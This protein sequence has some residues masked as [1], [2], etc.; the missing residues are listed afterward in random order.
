MNDPSIVAIIPARY[1]STRLPA[2]PLVDLRGKPMIRR[3]VEQVKKSELVGRVIVATDDERIASVVRSFGCEVAMT[4]PA[5]RT[6]SD[7]IAAVA[8]DL[9][10][11]ELIVNVQGDE[12]LIQ[13]E[14]IDEA[15][16]PLQEDESILMGTVVKKISTAEELKS[17]NCVKAVLDLDGNAVYFSRSPIPF[18]RE[19]A[20]IDDWHRKHRYY[21]HFG[22]YVYRRQFL[23]EFSSWPP[24]TLETAEQL[25]QLRVIEHGYRIRAVVTAHDS[26]PIDTAEDAERVRAILSRTVPEGAHN[27]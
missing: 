3:V 23:L 17:P 21:K 13:P 8:K 10:G 18:A 22:L 9:K 1:G 6:G 16:R 25:E 15:V 12:P 24:S 14:M 19:T 5:L 4:S 20:Q 27:G 11:A 26:V 7:R 2:K